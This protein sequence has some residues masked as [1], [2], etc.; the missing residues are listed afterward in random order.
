MGA[1]QDPGSTVPGEP[2][3]SLE[4][5]PV[6]QLQVPVKPDKSVA[7]T[8][9]RWHGSKSTAGRAMFSSTSHLKDDPF[10]PLRA[11]D[12]SRLHDEGLRVRLELGKKTLVMGT[13]VNGV[14]HHTGN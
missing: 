2:T 8:G 6:V 11:V 3:V 7:V 10:G 5:V 13:P 12:L 4:E 1:A 9:D 14:Y